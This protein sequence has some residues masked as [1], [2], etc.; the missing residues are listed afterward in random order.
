MRC[1]PCFVFGILG[2][3][4]LGACTVVNDDGST[5]DAV[6]RGREVPAGEFTN[7]VHIGRKNDR[8]DVKYGCTGTLITPKYVLTAAHCIEREDTRAPCVRPPVDPGGRGGIGRGGIGDPFTGYAESFDPASKFVVKHPTARDGARHKRV[9]VKNA[10][11][12]PRFRDDH[13]GWADAALLELEEPIEGT[14]LTPILTDLAETR[15]ALKVDGTATLVGFGRTSL[16]DDDGENR[17]AH[18]GD[19][20]IRRVSMAEADLGGGNTTDAAASPGDSGGPA[21][22]RLE[23]GELRVFGITSRGP[24]NFTSSEVP[25]IYGLMRYSLCDLQRVSGVALVPDMR[26]EASTGTPAASA[27]L[28][29]LCADA[30]ATP[31]QKDTLLALRIRVSEKTG[32]APSAVDCTALAAQ[33]ASWT[34]LDLSQHGLRDVSPL[35]SLTGL[36]SLNLDGN[37]ISAI[38]PLANLTRLR[39]LRLGWNDVRDLSTLAERERTGLAI[40]GKSAQRRTIKDTAFLRLCRKTDRTAA[41]SRQV[42][43]VERILWNPADPPFGDHCD[44]VNRELITMRG[45]YLGNARWSILNRQSCEVEQTFPATAVTDVDVLADLYALERVDVSVDESHPNKVTSVAPLASLPNLRELTITGNPVGDLST[46]DALVSGGLV[47][48]R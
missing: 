11:A 18:M 22:L 9:A 19:V 7:V 25:A 21:F 40:V 26:C 20:K 17:V 39:S 33:A 44:I 45:V 37:E 31:D 36:T 41:E 24:S 16:F 4:A 46:L 30:S 13:I 6:V 48:H 34:S 15:A 23:S 10:W 35:A 8:G 29:D 38:A 2:S 32:V 3:V 42:D 43:A 1:T 12:H 47:I 14:T 27:S 28:S 5:S